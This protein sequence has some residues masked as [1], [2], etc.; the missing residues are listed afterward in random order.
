MLEKFKFLGVL[1]EP[2]NSFFEFA[3]GFFPEY[4]GAASE[5]Q[6][7]RSTKTLRKLK[8]ETRV[9]GMST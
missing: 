5:E 8:E 9:G 6:G 4:L 3:L 7:E 2:K 1:N